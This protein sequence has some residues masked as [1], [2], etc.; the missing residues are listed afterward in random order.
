MEPRTKLRF[1]IWVSQCAEERVPTRIVEVTSFRCPTENRIDERHFC[2][3]FKIGEVISQ[4]HLRLDQ[5]KVSAKVAVF[6]CN[7]RGHFT[8]LWRYVFTS[9]VTLTENAR[10]GRKGQSCKIF[11]SQRFTKSLMLE[12]RPIRALPS[13]RGVLIPRRTLL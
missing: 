9:G 6:N 7:P 5:Q 3:V 10:K 4:E 1:Q 13:K 8:E 11:S 12:S 2:L